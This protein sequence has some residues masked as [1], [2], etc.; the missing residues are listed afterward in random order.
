MSLVGKALICL[1]SWA[2]QL[3]MLSTKCSPQGLFLCEGM[4]IYL[5]S[6]CRAPPYQ[7]WPH[8]VCLQ[9]FHPVQAGPAEQFTGDTDKLN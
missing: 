6:E 3:P 4:G 5:I 7:Q 8:G 1:A 2:T 9:A